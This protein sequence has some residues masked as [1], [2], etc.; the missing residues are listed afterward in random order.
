[1]K[2]NGNNG[3]LK[4]SESMYTEVLRLR[5]LTVGEL[6]DRYTEVFGEAPRSRNK[7]YLWKRIAYRLQELREGGISERAARRAEELARDA[8]LRMSPPKHAPLPTRPIKSRDHRL[9]PA[10]TLLTRAFG[11][12]EH[13]VRILEDGFEYEGNTFPSLSAVAREITGT[14]WNGFLFFGLGGN[15]GEP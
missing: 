10:G 1:M 15:G 11:R 14:R 12:K 5:G 9:P 13:R 8:D 4:G 3:E 7:D 2:N 6:R